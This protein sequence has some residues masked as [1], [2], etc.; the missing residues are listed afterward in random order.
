MPT[1]YSVMKTTELVVLLKPFVVGFILAEI[2]LAAAMST[3]LY[4]SHLGDLAPWYRFTAAA[5]TLGLCIY[6]F[7]LRDG[8][9]TVIK[10]VNSNRLDLLATFILGVL[11]QT[12]IYQTTEKLHLDVF[13]VAANWVPLIYPMLLFI[14]LSPILQHI[15]AKKHTTVQ[16]SFFLSDKEIKSEHEDL[17]GIKEQAVRFAHSVMQSA[18]VFGLDG[19]WGAGKTS[20]INIAESVW[21][22]NSKFLVCRFEPLR[23]AA[24]PDITNRLIRELASIIQKRAYAPEFWLTANRFSRLIKGKAEVSFFGFKF[25]LEPSHETVEDLLDDI[26]EVLRQLDLRIIIVIDDLDRLDA[27]SVNNI[28]FATK[29]TLQL[30]QAT[31]VLCY[32]TEILVGLQDENSRAREFLEKFITIKLSLFIDK[33]AICN[34]L[35]S[36]WKEFVIPDGTT[37]PDAIIQLSVIFDE[38]AKLIEGDNSAYYSPL[39]GNMRKVKRFINAIRLMQIEKINFERTDFNKQDLIHL[40]LLHLNYPGAFRTIYS[41]ETQGN[42][43]YFSIKYDDK[44]RRYTNENKFVELTNDKDNSITL[45]FLLKQLFDAN[46]ITWE[47]ND[48]EPSESDYASRACFNRGS[49][50]N[51]ENFL[52]FIVRIETPEPQS[53]LVLYKN[54]LKEIIN[55]AKINSVLE[56]QDFTSDNWEYAHERL[57]TQIVTEAHLLPEPVVQHAIDTLVNYLPKMP[58]VSLDFRSSRENLIYTLITLLERS[59]LDLRSRKSDDSELKIAWHIFGEH[60]FKGRGLLHQLAATERGALGCYDLLVF[61]LSCS[62]DRN[63]N[64][65]RLLTALIKDQDKHAETIGHMDKLTIFS[66]RKL[67][68]NIFKIFKDRYIIKGKNILTEIDDLSDESLLGEIKSDIQTNTN[69]NSQSFDNEISQRISIRR[70]TLKSFVVYQLVNSFPPTGSGV[71]CGYYDECGTDDNNGIAKMMNDYLFE[72]CFNP[73]IAEKNALY[74]FDNCVTHLKSSF[75]IG[76]LDDNLP[77]ST[78]SITGGLNPLALGTFWQ[79]HGTTIRNIVELNSEREVLTSN[80]SIKYNTIMIKVFFALDNSTNE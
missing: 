56:R 21:Q 63:K 70:F 64:N 30:T 45:A 3:S 57:W 10:M 26:D 4:I 13:I 66:M 40:I 51:L 58:L 19:P 61:R 9:K 7:Y 60:E 59:R 2:L 31:Y 35:R 78:D 52:K 28:L 17:L 53:T 67:T 73:E 37:P 39:V 24:E 76:D 11:A 47:N 50:R 68:Q 65:H 1:K 32:D 29:R 38:L 41:E 22:K 12:K 42:T 71:G 75:F 20:F 43:G 15:R 5:L 33:S 74:F 79:K 14:L 80:G 49:I 36:R 72:V 34:F 77:V 44:S 27:R 8:H 48:D 69:G 16:S 46:T 25:S 23:F 62:A 55:G 18:D 6:Y 54:A